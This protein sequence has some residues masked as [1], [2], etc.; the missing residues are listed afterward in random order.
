LESTGINLQLCFCEDIEF[1]EEGCISEMSSSGFFDMVTIKSAYLTVE[2]FSEQCNV[3]TTTVR[4]WIR[5]GKIRNAIKTGR[6]WLISELTRIPSRGYEDV[7]YFWD[8]P[9]FE[10]EKE[11]PFLNGY[12]CIY[13]FQDDK[14]KTM[15]H[16]ILGAPGSENRIKTDFTTQER[17]KLELALITNE[18]VKSEE[19]SLNIIYIPSKR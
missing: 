15:Y 6:D 7:T 5:R 1:D 2:Q 12:K 4:Q 14:N 8:F 9:L 18:I 3:K 11:Y 16:G 19:S 13:F 10:L 17:E